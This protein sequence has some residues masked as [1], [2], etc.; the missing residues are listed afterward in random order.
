MGMGGELYAPDVLLKVGLRAGLNFWRRENNLPA[1]D[2][3]TTISRTYCS[4][5]SHYIEF[6]NSYLHRNVVLS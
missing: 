5:P 6:A 3:E 2:N 1:T 4:K